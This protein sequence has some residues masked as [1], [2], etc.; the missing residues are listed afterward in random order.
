[1]SRCRSRATATANEKAGGARRAARLHWSLLAVL[2]GALSACAPRPAPALHPASLALDF[3]WPHA[4]EPTLRSAF[5]PPAP[6]KA[7]TL[8]WNPK[9][10]SRR[11]IAEIAGQQCLAFGRSAKPASRVAQNGASDVQ[12][13]DCVLMIGKAGGGAKG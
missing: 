5:A 7:V 8:R 2:A 6:P 4:T 9:D 1:M 11:E 12:R 13:F 3:A 10:Y